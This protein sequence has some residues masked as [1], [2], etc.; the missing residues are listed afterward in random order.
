MCMRQDGHILTILP[1][2][3]LILEMVRVTARIL[4]RSA[5]RRVVSICM[6]LQLPVFLAEMH[7]LIATLEN[8]IIM[9]RGRNRTALRSIGSTQEHGLW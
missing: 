4:F 1:I 7:L 6:A 3:R 5:S 8:G 2:F 9:A